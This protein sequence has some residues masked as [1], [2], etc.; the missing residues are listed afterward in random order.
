MQPTA[1]ALNFTQI[2]QPD[3]VRGDENLLIVAYLVGDIL[4]IMIRYFRDI[5]PLGI[6]PIDIYILLFSHILGIMTN[7]D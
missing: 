5:S 4:G 2:T 6:T 3:Q 7:V 1:N